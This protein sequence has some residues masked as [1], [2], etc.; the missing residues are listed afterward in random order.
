MEIRTDLY[1]KGDFKGIDELEKKLLKQNAEHKDW[2]ASEEMMKL[3]KN[4]KGLYLHCLPADI[5]GIS[6][7][8]GEVAASVFDRYRD[9]LYK[10]ASYK[11]YVIAAMIYLAKMKDPI[12]GF[13]KMIKDGVERR[14]DL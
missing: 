12:K 13:E 7:E 8:E 3:T 4:G 1:G 11:P 10:E 6:C 9:D 5:T 2:T 14:T